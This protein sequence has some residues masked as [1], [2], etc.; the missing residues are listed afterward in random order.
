[1]HH[2]MNVIRNMHTSRSPENVAFGTESRKGTDKRASGISGVSKL[3]PDC[4][5]EGCFPPVDSA[6]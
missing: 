5:G 1:M 2:K 4:G 3:W 6:Q